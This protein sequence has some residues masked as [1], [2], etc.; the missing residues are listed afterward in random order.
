VKTFDIYQHPTLGF[1][2]V[3]RG[4]SWPAFCFSWI[5]AFVKQIW[6]LGVILLAANIAL[7]VLSGADDAGVV[8]ALIYL[9]GALVCGKFGNEWRASALRARGFRLVL[10]TVVAQSTEAAVVTAAVAKPSIAGALAVELLGA[11]AKGACEGIT[12]TVCEI[13]VQETY[14]FVST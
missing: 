6:M 9:V 11:V 12:E 13:A 5:W 3:K 7:E 2:A 14:E 10:S 4:F 8:T 1:E